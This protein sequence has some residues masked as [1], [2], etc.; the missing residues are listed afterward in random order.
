MDNNLEDTKNKPKP[1]IFGLFRSYFWPIGSLVILAVASSGLGLILPKII[2]KSIDTYARNTFSLSTLVW[3]FGATTFAIYIATYMQSIVQ[4]YTSERV[5]RDLRE[6]LSGKISRQSNAFIEKITAGKLLTNLTADVD[7]IKLFISLAVS[8]IVSSVIIII[9]ASILLLSID[10]QL[11]LA[12]L[13]IVPILSVLFFVLF[14]RAKTL[15]KKGREVID[16]LNRVINESIMGAGLIRVLNSEKTEY[17]KFSAANQEAR[18]VGIQILKIFASLIP[19]VT[20]IASLASLTILIL[21]GHFVIN[22]SMTLGNFAAFNSYVVLLIFPIIMLGFMSNVIAQATASYE[23]ITDVLNAEEE[24][25]AG[26]LTSHLRGDIELNNVTLCYNDKSVLRDVS[27]KIPA[28]SKTAIIGPTA[29]GKTLLMHLL[30]G[31]IKPDEGVIKYDGH[32]INAYTPATLHQQIG[33]VFQDS[34]IFNLTLRENIA[35][36]ETVKDKD[37]DKALDTA[38]LADF[39]TALPQGLNTVVSERG[40]SLSGGQ[41]QRIMLARALAINPTIL[42]LDDFT[43]RVDNKTEQSILNNIEM[44]YPDITLVSVT[45]KISA[46]EKYDQIILLMEGEVIAA[47]KHDAL[48]E[49]CPEY[50]QIFNSQQSTNEYE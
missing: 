5:A 47:G 12:V 49:S 15:F 1:N 10:W 48:L 33:L 42:L 38:E 31:L 4:T 21:G 19:M 25:P 30:I 44:N 14:S 20:F 23:R 46:V 6:E 11:A 45:Q 41:K 43:A 3:E 17:G 37:L 8:S 35:F 32:D 26:T 29:A 18:L 50:V 39:I 13:T 16:W 36:S 40:S 22:G 34:V 7:S 2:S 24:A 9:G 28:N 27:F